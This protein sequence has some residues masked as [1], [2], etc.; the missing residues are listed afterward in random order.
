MVSV[1]K[2]NNVFLHPGDIFASKRFFIATTILGSCVSVCLWDKKFRYAGINHYLLPYWTGQGL[3]T[4]RYGNVTINLLIEKM[5]EFG[6]QKKNITAKV[7]GGVDQ[8]AKTI[9]DIGFRNW[10]LAK[11]HLEEADI[12]ITAI[13]VGGKYGRKIAFNSQ[14]GSVRV[15]Y[16]NFTSNIYRVS[17]R[18]VNA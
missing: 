13:D 5:L 9:Y 4:P 18:F 11:E 8:Y 7:F 6:S 3:S 10:K 17:N 16:V 15:K 14:T 2:K 1:S 12:P